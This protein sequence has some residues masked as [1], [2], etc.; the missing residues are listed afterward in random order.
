MKRTILAV[1]I[2][3]IAFASAVAGQENNANVAEAKTIIKAF[4]EQLK[5]ELGHR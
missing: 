4:F 5:G 3:S 1:M 2:S